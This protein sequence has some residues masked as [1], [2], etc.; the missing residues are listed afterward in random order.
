MPR[1]KVEFRYL[2]G[3]RQN[4]FR[5]VR[6]M[7]GWAAEGGR[8]D[9]WLTVPMVAYT[10]EDGCPAFK[11][12]IAFDGSQVGREFVWGVLL[13]APGRANI[14]GL[15]TEC[16]SLEA[17]AMHRCFTLENRDMVESYWLT[18]CR[19]LG[20]NKYYREGAVSP[21]LRFSVWAPN[22]LGAE[23]LIAA[24]DGG[25]YIHDDGRGLKK[26]YTM[27][28]DEDGLWHSDPDEPDFAGF[29]AWI[30]RPYMFRITREDGSVVYRTD[31]YSRGQAGTGSVDPA[32]EEWNGQ[33]SQLEGTKSCSLVVDPELVPPMYPDQAA[34]EE[35]QDEKDFWAH[36]FNPNR[37][38]PNRV[39]DM[40]IYEMHIG[41]L[42]TGSE[43]PG[44][45]GDA[46]L[47]LD[48]LVDLGI[49][50]IELLPI[51]AFEGESGWGYGT[52][53][54]YAITRGP[55]GRA[56]FRHFVRA[57]HRRG[58]AVIMDVVYNHYTPDG[59]RAEWMYDSSRHDHNI[60]YMYHGRDE[61]YP[62]PEGGYFDNMSTGY[63]PNM[64]EEILFV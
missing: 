4:I 38:L 49:N 31:L 28:R 51:S 22:A 19:R 15:M 46:M 23:T 8:S 20:A 58:I 50:T 52:S 3:I 55:V 54:Y 10:A 45:F 12:E 5:N 26:A 39:E 40:V 36:E 30:G 34:G 11:A 59:E 21:G 48:Y 60:Y 29:A 47:M 18:H 62:T 16:G 42:W 37:P 2:T 25:G 56:Q 63:L 43:T 35:W 27:T 7:G 57:C 1:I 32:K 6:L 64:A 17:A 41:G 24:D 44:A 14:W 61:D 33:S 9:K 53:H 13:D